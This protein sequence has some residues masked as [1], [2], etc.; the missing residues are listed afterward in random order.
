ME[1]T[2]LITNFKYATAMARLRYWMEPTPLP[3]YNDVQGQA[4]Y[5]DA[6]YNRD[7]DD[8][9]AAFLRSYQEIIGGS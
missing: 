4:E 5:W 8:D 1:D 3:V 9:T 7:G 2:E 6:T